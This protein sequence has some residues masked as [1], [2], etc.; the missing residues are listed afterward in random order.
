M[1]LFSISIDYLQKY[2]IDVLYLVLY[3]LRT[4]I[5]IFIINNSS[6]FQGFLLTDSKPKGNVPIKIYLLVKC[7]K[8]CQHFEIYLKFGF[9]SNRIF[10]R[11]NIIY[12]L[13][14]ILCV[15][16]VELGRLH[17]FY[18]QFLVNIFFRKICSHSILASHEPHHSIGQE[19]AI[20]LI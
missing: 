1:K 15:L 4:I 16:K 7:W 14:C 2:S 6:S 10:K 19:R 9:L 17:I 13:L 3:S 20:N 11:K 18:V 12:I 8:H 5:L